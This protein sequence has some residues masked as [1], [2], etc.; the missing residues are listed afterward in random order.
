[1]RGQ[2]NPQGQT[3]SYFSCESR[4]TFDDPS[5]VRSAADVLRDVCGL[6]AVTPRLPTAVSL[7]AQRHESRARAS[8]LQL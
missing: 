6:I 2:I 4:A 7:A 3:F 1:M 5:K 8:A